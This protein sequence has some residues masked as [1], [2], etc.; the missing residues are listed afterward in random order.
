MAKRAPRLQF[1]PRGCPLADI[2][3][4]VVLAVAVVRL[5]RQVV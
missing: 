3:C 5:A 4:A 1:R 2:A